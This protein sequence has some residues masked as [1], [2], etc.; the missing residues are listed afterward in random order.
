MKI[1]SGSFVL[2]LLLLTFQCSVNAQ[3]SIQ[4]DIY[5]IKLVFSDEYTYSE[6]SSA[7]TGISDPHGILLHKDTLL[8]TDWKGNNIV[9]L[10]KECNLIRMIGELGSAPLEF[11][12]PTGIT[13]YHG[14]I[15]IIDS[16][17]NR[18]QVLNEDF[19]YKCSIRIPEIPGAFFTD[20]AVNS[21]YIYIN[22]N[23]IDDFYG[24]IYRGSMQEEFT[25]MTDTLYGPLY[26]C[27]DNVYAVN[28][29]ECS[30]E[31]DDYCAKTGRNQLFLILSDGLQ[32]IC[33]LPK[34]YTPVDF[35]INQD[36]LFCL[37]CSNFT[38]NEHMMNGQYQYTL[39]DFSP[40]RDNIVSLD[41]VMAG[42]NT[43]SLY[44]A[45]YVEGIMIRIKKEN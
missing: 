34:D 16:G 25:K 5:S 40:L 45:N 39:F 2:L 12:K 18:I 17:N 15:F 9:L 23:S 4:P 24:G 32:V 30:K 19:S 42:D 7:I 38:L 8:V 44:I 20:I 10:D 3:E 26:A 22:S 27:G 35:I 14:E 33:D 36:R 11:I 31:G 13:S 43:D 41:A 28:T 37:S 29:L 21:E 6:Y 1:I